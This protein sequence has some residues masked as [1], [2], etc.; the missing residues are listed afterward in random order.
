MLR[1]T[2]G[3][4]EPREDFVAVAV[5]GGCSGVSEL[6]VVDLFFSFSRSAFRNEAS[7]FRAALSASIRAFIRASSSASSLFF[8][9]RAS[10][11]SC[12]ALL[13]DADGVVGVESG[14]LC[15]PFALD[16]NVG[17]ATG[18]EEA[19]IEGSEGPYR[20]SSASVFV[21]LS[22]GSGVFVCGG[23]V[24]AALEPGIGFAP[25][26]RRIELMKSSFVTSLLSWTCS[27]PFWMTTKV[28]TLEMSEKAARNPASVE[29]ASS[30]R[31]TAFWTSRFDSYVFDI[32]A[33][34]ECVFRG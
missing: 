24:G 10:R 23:E 27:C 19:G 26:T 1:A 20:S 15:L 30:R 5:V 22:L 17:T 2:V 7:I 21:G 16:D 8:F 34:F 32:S 25:S 31:T 9:R 18:A 14:A 33:R 4:F 13:A 6:C 3:E 29:P 28:G 12:W 11:A